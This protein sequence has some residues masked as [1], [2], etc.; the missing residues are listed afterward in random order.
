MPF[1]LSHPAAVLPLLR[2]PFSAAALVAG[3]V[4]P[5]MPYFARSTPIPV[6]AESWYEPYMNAT[7]SHGLLGALTVSLPYALALFGLYLVARRPVGAL[8]P[9]TAP[10]DPEPGGAS[11]LLRRGGWALLS[12][13]IGIATHLVW[14]SFTHVDGY[15]VLNVPF[16]TTQLA[17][18]LTWAR[19]LQHVSTVG[20]LAVIAVYLWRR[21]SRLRPGTAAGRR[22]SWQLLWIVVGVA[23]VGA[24]ANTVEF[25][26]GASEL[27]ARDLVE[28]VLSHVATGAGAALIAALFLYVAVWWAV[29]GVREV[30]GVRQTR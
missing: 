22:S 27:R 9:A 10:R 18:D 21:R 30:S 19:A 28:V 11:A 13:L 5:D 3:A 25:W 14:D 4:A 17:G 6:T 7:T 1:T 16:L 23:A 24:I 15:V 26:G 29:R 20:G 2:R 8:L 12:L